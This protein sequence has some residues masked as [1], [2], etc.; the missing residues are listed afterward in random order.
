MILLQR[1]QR[2]RIRQRQNLLSPDFRTF[3]L[4]VDTLC[5]VSLVSLRVIR[6]AALHPYPNNFTFRIYPSEF[7][8]PSPRTSSP[9][10]LPGNPRANL[11]ANPRASL[12]TRSP[13]C[14]PTN[15]E[16]NS[17]TNLRSNLPS[18]PRSHYLSRLRGHLL[19]GTPSQGKIKYK[20]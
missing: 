2:R 1:A 4:L 18:S 6:V 16:T 14:F 11:P 20:K 8:N 3:P 9:G 7:K 17:P 13:A 15:P 5:L 19:S 12:R 10:N